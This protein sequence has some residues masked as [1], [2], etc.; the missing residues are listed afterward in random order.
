MKKVCILFS[1]ILS[2]AIFFGAVGNAFAVDSN[3]TY[4]IG[5]KYVGGEHDDDCT[6][7]VN[8]AYANYS[9]M[10][11]YSHYKSTIPTRNL[12][13]NPCDSGLRPICHKV[14]FF[15]GHAS[16]DHMVFKAGSGADY[17]TGVFYKEDF[18]SPTTYYK[19]AGIQDNDTNMNYVKLITFAGCKTANTNTTTYNL[20]YNAKAAGADTSV[21]FKNNIY[22][23]TTDGINWCNAYNYYLRLG[24]SVASALVL[25][26]NQYG[27]GTG[28]DQYHIY[29]ATNT[30]LTSASTS[31]SASTVTNMSD[32]ISD[33]EILTIDIN[34]DVD[35][36][37]MYDAF[38]IN[39]DE[40]ELDLSEIINCIQKIDNNFNPN[41]YNLSVNIYAPQEN[42]GVI[43][44]NYCIGDKILTNKTFS[45]IVENNKANQILLH[46]MFLDNQTGK[47]NNP[48]NEN[49]L[50]ALVQNFEEKQE[51]TVLSDSIINGSIE[52][53]EQKYIYNYQA[54]V[55]YY[56]DSLCYEDPNLDNAIVD[57]HIT[58]YLRGSEAV[59]LNVADFNK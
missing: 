50:L 45:V 16:Y 6:V 23:R 13:L 53:H 56:Q 55:L 31:S 21:G 44:F 46:K 57:K 34:I 3:R 49:E 48:V 20:A 27:P 8:N 33:P 19:Y 43:T 1:I 32:R 36:D 38:G 5:C 26:S 17:L 15:N 47:I 52:S 59:L 37:K 35:V 14:V 39:I 2:F 18:T 24:H 4:S 10:P 7:N 58:K 51:N 29:G 41:D 54:D 9:R 22:S 42:S 12:M 25:A 28:L 40:Y 11:Y 30:T